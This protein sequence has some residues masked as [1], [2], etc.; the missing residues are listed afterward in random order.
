MWYGVTVRMASTC[1][2]VARIISTCFRIISYES[3]FCAVL[4][5]ITWLQLFEA[6]F[7]LFGCA[8]LRSGEWQCGGSTVSGSSR[9]KL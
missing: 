2:I 6:Q 3:K 4:Q 5:S 1:N 8:D 7:A 9:H